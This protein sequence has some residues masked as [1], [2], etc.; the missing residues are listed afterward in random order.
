MKLYLLP[1]LFCFM[2]HGLKF[3]LPWKDIRSEKLVLTENKEYVFEN[4]KDVLL[5]VNELDITYRTMDD[6]LQSKVFSENYTF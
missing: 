1:L 2:V 5:G 4:S 6:I 3:S